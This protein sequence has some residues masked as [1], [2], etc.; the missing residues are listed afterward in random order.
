MQKWDLDF[1]LN[2][3]YLTFT[4][5]VNTSFSPAGIGI[6]NDETSANTSVILTTNRRVQAIGLDQSA[7]LV[8]LTSFDINTLKLESVARGPGQFVDT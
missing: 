6:Q 2:I 5:G 3:L 8:Y 7:F 4:E 1:N